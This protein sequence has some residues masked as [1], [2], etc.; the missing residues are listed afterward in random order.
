M[1]RAARPVG[2]RPTS[3]SSRCSPA[4]PGRRDAAPR[5]PC[6][7]AALL[8]LGGDVELELDGRSWRMLRG[9][10]ANIPPGTPHAW[11]MRSDRSKLALFTMNDRVGAAFVAM[12]IPHAN[13][14]L[15][16]RRYG[17]HRRRTGS[18]TPRITATFSCVPE[19]A[20]GEAAVRVANLVLPSAPGPYVLLDG[21]GE[22]FGGNTFLARNANTT[23]NFLF[24]ITEGGPVARP[25][26]RTFTRATS[27]TSSASTAKHSAGRTAR[28]CPLKA[29]DY[30]QAPPRNLHGFK[31]TQQYNRFAAFLTPG[32]FE[33][34]FVTAAAVR[35]RGAW[36]PAALGAGGPR[37][38]LAVHA[39]RPAGGVDMFR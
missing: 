30:F 23:G 13:A 9:D 33:Q 3:T 38:R 24:I 21:G 8:V 10:F 20:A 17:R 14:A 29:G 12:G 36:W 39:E 28:P 16:D 25:C 2:H 22:R 26:R 5:T 7:H 34:F 37:W 32:I 15:P 35:R 4:E 18:R 19:P 11:T 31:L 1:T 27:R 6:S